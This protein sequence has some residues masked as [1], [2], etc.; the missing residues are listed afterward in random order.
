[1]ELLKLPKR[2]FG[3]I[4]HAIVEFWIPVLDVSRWENILEHFLRRKRHR[5]NWNKRKF[6][7]RDGIQSPGC[8]HE[9]P[10]G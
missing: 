6:S 1:M 9:Y 8:S 4:S 5:I 2:L 3:N 10:K 7:L